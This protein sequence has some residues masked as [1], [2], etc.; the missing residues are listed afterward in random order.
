MVREYQGTRHTVTV[1][2]QGFSWQGATCNRAG[3]VRIFSR[4]E[5]LVAKDGFDVT[6]GIPFSHCQALGDALN[7]NGSEK[8]DLMDDAASKPAPRQLN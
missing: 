1:L 8:Q 5:C 6:F 3:E 7:R 4:F 2:P